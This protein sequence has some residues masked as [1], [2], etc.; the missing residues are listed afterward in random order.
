ME[1]KHQSLVGEMGRRIGSR[2]VFRVVAGHGIDAI[3]MMW[4]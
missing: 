4:P 3:S 1:D 2:H